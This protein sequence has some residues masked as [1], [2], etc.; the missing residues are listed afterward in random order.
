MNTEVHQTLEPPEPIDQPLKTAFPIREELLQAPSRP[1]AVSPE[2][3][4]SMMGRFR[5]IPELTL[6]NLSIKW[7][8]QHPDDALIGTVSRDGRVQPFSLLVRSF[9]GRLMLRCVSPIGRD[10][11]GIEP[12]D[13]GREA[14]ELPVQVAVERAEKEKSWLFSAEDE[15]LLSGPEHDAQRV[16]WLIDRVTAAADRLERKLLEGEADR[17]LDDFRKTLEGGSELGD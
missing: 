8:D 2:S 4:A 11:W 9:E 6:G 14:F 7:E 15:I 16:T 3:T 5:R 13:L 12:D 17:T 10:D 1:L